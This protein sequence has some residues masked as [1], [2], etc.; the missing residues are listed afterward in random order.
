MPKRRE[1]YYPNLEAEIARRGINVKDM[2]EKLN[3]TY[4]TFARRM[5]GVSEF[6]LS[7][8]IT[9]MAIFPDQALEKLFEHK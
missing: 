8:I 1:P 2:L 5:S 3:L 7:E 6:H 9:I 4:R